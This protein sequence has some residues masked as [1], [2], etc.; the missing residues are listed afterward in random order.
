MKLFCLLRNKNSIPVR[1]YDL[2]IKEERACVT[3]LSSSQ[4]FLNV[5]FFL[6]DKD[7]SCTGWHFSTCD[8][9]LLLMLKCITIIAII[10]HLF[11][12]NDWECA[13]NFLY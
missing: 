4:I 6:L 8:V 10:D 13:G 1:K 12:T 3:R 7:S 11:M 9:M 5:L 2:N